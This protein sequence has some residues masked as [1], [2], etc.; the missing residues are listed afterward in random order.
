MDK[1]KHLTDRGGQYSRWNVFKVDCVE[2]RTQDRDAP[3]G[4]S[5]AV[6]ESPDY[7]NRRLTST[8]GNNGDGSK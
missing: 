4:A 3:R 8:S 6:P 1:T 5:H 7:S 2:V